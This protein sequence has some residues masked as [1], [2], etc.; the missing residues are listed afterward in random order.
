MNKKS[1]AGKT[2]CFS[3]ALRSVAISAAIVAA[4]R[5]RVR[6]LC[7]SQRTFTGGKFTQILAV[8]GVRHEA[9]S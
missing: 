9:A 6:F 2:F 5:L 4:V 7:F 3:S 8:I 1:S